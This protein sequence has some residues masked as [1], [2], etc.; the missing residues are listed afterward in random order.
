MSETKKEIRAF[1]GIQ[2]MH[3]DDELGFF[4]GENYEFISY[5]PTEIRIKNSR[6]S[7]VTV[8]RLY[9]ESWFL[10]TDYADDA[11]NVKEVEKSEIPIKNI[12]SAYWYGPNGDELGLTQNN[13]YPILERSKDG[14]HYSILNN[15][16]IPVTV[17]RNKLS[18]IIYAE[19]DREDPNHKYDHVN[20][21][22][23]KTNDKEVWEYMIEIYGL[24]KF[25][26]FCELNVFKYSMRVGRKP[27]ATVED[28]LGKIKWYAEKIK[29]LRDEPTV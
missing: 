8:T 9:A 12:G 26:A 16:N 21:D 23:Y 19:V 6:G 3:N 17:N 18:R 4:I 20:P 25:I 1:R 14:T 28:D 10:S 7:I 15:D 24:D 2:G 29:E 11:S 27:G 5:S 13:E 22:H